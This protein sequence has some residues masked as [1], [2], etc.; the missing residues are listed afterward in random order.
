MT[1]LE[2]IR[3][4]R[5][6]IHDFGSGLDT[7]SE[8]DAKRE[9]IDP[10]LN[11]LGWKGL[12]RVRQEYKVRSGGRMDYA[13]LGASGKAI[14]LIEAKAPREDPTQ[15]VTQLLGY[16]FEEGVDICVLTSGIKWLMYLPREKGQPDDRL[17]ARFDLAKDNGEA[18]ASLL[19]QCLEYRNV[20]SGAAERAAKARLQ[21]IRDARVVQQ[22][23]PRAVRRLLS[24][25]DDSFNRLVQRTV[26][27][28]EGV[29][30]TPDQVR[31]SLNQ[32]SRLLPSSESAN[33]VQPDPVQAGSL[34]VESPQTPRKGLK[35]APRPA[36]YSLWNRRYVFRTWS[37]MLVDVA[38]AVHSRHEHEF[39]TRVSTS[40]LMQGR[41]RAYVST[42]AEQIRRA[43]RIPGTTYFLDVNWN[44]TNME[45]R[46]RDM[47]RVFGYDPNELTIEYPTS[48]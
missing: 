20:T 46:A 28:E 22:A 5:E 4:A 17:F 23:I 14:G 21:S 36:S 39:L 6:E 24:G 34:S 11:Q 33:A 26:Q 16:A 31:D 32:L 9:F 44:A 1:L 35:F 7:L 27:Q 45:R 30:P 10:I 43:T 13:L 8:A 18:V 40:P 29:R 38:S 2:Q 41:T 48:D 42:S 47:L 25:T 12:S 37:A 3:L 15:H 19:Q